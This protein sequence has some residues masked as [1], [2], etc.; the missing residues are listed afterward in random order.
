MEDQHLVQ[1]YHDSKTRINET[2]IVLLQVLHFKSETYLVFQQESSA[3][4]QFNNDDD[5]NLNT[6]AL[7]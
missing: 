2:T 3:V 4:G 6:I 5:K 7:K 1:K